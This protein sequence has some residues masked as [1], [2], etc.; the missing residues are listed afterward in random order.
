M[1]GVKDGENLLK[2]HRRHLYQLL[3]NEIEISHW[4]VS[5]GYGVL[6][7]IAGLSVLPAK[8]LG[9]WAC[10]FCLAPILADFAG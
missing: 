7:L 1:T 2:P 3:A 5:V 9:I 6:Q 8:P 4:K 10:Y